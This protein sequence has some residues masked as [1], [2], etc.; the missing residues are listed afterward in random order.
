MLQPADP[1]SCDQLHARLLPAATC[2]AR[3][4]A[5]DSYGRPAHDP[6]GRC[7]RGAAVLAQLRAGGWEPAGARRG[8]R[9]ILWS[10]FA[11]QSL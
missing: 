3:H 10:V 2:A 1:M 8:V 7:L 4:D 5:K 6:C 11:R 9:C